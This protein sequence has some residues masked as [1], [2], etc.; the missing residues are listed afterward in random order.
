MTTTITG[1]V[2]RCMLG[3]LV[4]FAIAGVA[5][6][7]SPASPAN[8]SVGDYVHLHRAPGSGSVLFGSGNQIGSDSYTGSTTCF[9]AAGRSTGTRTRPTV[10]M[11]TS[12]TRGVSNNT[13][14]RDDNH[15]FVNRVPAASIGLNGQSNYRVTVTY[16]DAGLSFHIGVFIGF[17]YTI[18]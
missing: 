17:V 7:V 9:R 2:V 16:Q 14:M 10:A 15:D 18:N 12:G 8:A 4:A 3:L 13:V 5:A 11:C 1:R 6:I